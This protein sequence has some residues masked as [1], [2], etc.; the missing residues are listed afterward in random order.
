M[1]INNKNKFLWNRDVHNYNTRQMNK[2]YIPF[3]HYN[4]TDRAPDVI[5]VRVNVLPVSVRSCDN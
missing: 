1:C 2:S 5:G 4:V 3:S